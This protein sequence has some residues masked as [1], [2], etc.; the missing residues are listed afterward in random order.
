MWTLFANIERDDGTFSRKRASKR[1]SLC[2]SIRGI[3]YVPIQKGE[4][5]AMISYKLERLFSGEL[6]NKGVYLMVVER[7]EMRALKTAVFM[8]AGA[9][10]Y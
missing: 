1:C 3:R 10:Q 7:K 8:H 5:D 4:I 9:L 6:F 2:S